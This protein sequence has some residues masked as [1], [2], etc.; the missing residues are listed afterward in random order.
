MDQKKALEDR[1]DNVEKR[2]SSVDER[3]SSVESHVDVMDVST[4]A[5]Y[6]EIQVKLDNLREMHEKTFTKL[7]DFLV[8]MDKNDQELAIQG[9]QVSRLEKRVGVLE[10]TV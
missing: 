8:K 7:D 9:E 3:L 6:K 2:L 4:R 5:E 10:Q 1:F